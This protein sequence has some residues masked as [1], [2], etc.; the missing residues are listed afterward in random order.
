MERRNFHCI[1]RKNII[2]EKGRSTKL[3]GRRKIMFFF[4]INTAFTQPPEWHS[5]Y[6]N[7]LF[8]QPPSC[9][10]SVHAGKKNINFIVLSAY[11]LH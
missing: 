9:K 1:W 5:H 10:N 4:L 3:N 2:L 11:T 6:K 7:K 8:L